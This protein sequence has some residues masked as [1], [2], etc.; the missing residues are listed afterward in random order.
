MCSGLP[1]QFLLH[2][3]KDSFLRIGFDI[4]NF[5]WILILP[6]LHLDRI[7]LFAVTARTP[8]SLVVWS[9]QIGFPVSSSYMHCC[10]GI[11]LFFAFFSVNRL[12]AVFLLQ[13]GCLEPE[14]PVFTVPPLPFLLFTT[15][16]VHTYMC[17]TMC[18]T[19]SV[20]RL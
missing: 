20:I 18:I 10:T 8:K 7:L 3:G 11:C 2:W 15:V 1:H 17:I 5:I 9:N 13:V 16:C 4:V 6:P 12:M 19:V 14:H